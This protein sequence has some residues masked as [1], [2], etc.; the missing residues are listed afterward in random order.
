MSKMIDIKVSARAALF[1]QAEL[2]AHVFNKMQNIDSLAD[3][4]SVAELI[5][6]L[7]TLQ[8]LMVAY[9]HHYASCDCCT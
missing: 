2:K 7:R 8:K 9:N 6:E 4:E 1:L 3:F 5:A